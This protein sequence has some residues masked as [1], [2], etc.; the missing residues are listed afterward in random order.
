MSADPLRPDEARA[1]RARWSLVGITLALT[2]GVVAYRLTHRVGLSQ[3]GAFFVGLPAVLAISVALAPRAKTVRGTTFKAVTFGLLLS[4]ILVGEGFVCIVMA[5]P[6]F[7]LIAMPIAGV[8]ERR[9]ERGSPPGQTYALV[10]LPVLLFSLEGVVDATTLPVRNRVAASQVVAATP[11]EVEAA[12]ASRPAFVK[13]LPAFLRDAGFPRPLGAEGSGLHVGAGRHILF[14]GPDGPAPLDLRVVERGPGRVV[15]AVEQDETPIAGWLSLRRSV[16]TW[17]RTSDGATR[18]RW[19]LEFDR[20]LAPAFYFAPLERYASRLAAGYL[21]R[22]VAT[23][24][25]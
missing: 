2:A 19:E 11:A 3:T 13:P 21:I 9:R 16:V 7:Y 24:H 6:L 1:S 23:P 12:L 17:W 25:G 22:T 14:S 8:I 20:A 15:F 18:V 4:G 10:V 5:A